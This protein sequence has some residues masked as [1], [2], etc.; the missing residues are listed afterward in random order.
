MPPIIFLHQIRSMLNSHFLGQWFTIEDFFPPRTAKESQEVQKATKFWNAPWVHLG[1]CQD[2]LCPDSSR[3]Q[4]SF[5]LT[6]HTSVPA[7]LLWTQDMA[8][9]NLVHY[10]G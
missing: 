3:T 9:H 5:T 4:R 6:S 7:Q 1:H 2:A 8:T 10:H